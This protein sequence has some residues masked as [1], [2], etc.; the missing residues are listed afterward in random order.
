MLSAGIQSNATW[1]EQ[2]KD[3]A[4]NFSTQPCFNLTL[5]QNT[6]AFSKARCAYKYFL[7][8]P[9]SWKKVIKFIHI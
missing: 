4:Q 2:M 3:E 8:L 1:H 5:L 9:T 7:R 6:C